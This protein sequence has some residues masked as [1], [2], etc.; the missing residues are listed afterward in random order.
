MAELFEAACAA[1]PGALALVHGET[2][3][4]YAELN[5]RANRLAWRL[6][7]RGVGPGDLVGL[8]VPRSVEMIVAWLGVLKSGAAYLPIDPS[9]PA[10]R[11]ALILDDARPAVIVSTLEVAPTLGGAEVVLVDQAGADLTASDPADA[12]R[13]RP[14]SLDDAAYVIFTSGSTGRP[15]GCVVTHRGVGGMAAE[16]I[17]RLRIGPG[18]RFLL[19]V[20]ISFDVS[21]ADIAMTLFAGATLVVP[22]PDEQMAGE[23]LADVIERHGVTHTDLVAAM[24]ASLPDRPL[25]TMTS[26]IVGGEACSR[27]LAARWAPGRRLVHVYGPTESTVVATMSEP[28]TGD[29]APPM[30]RPIRGIAA[31]VLDA[32]L[33]PVPDG[34]PGELYLAGA[35][36]ARG[37]LNR[38]ALTAERFV[39]NPFDA[40][41]ARMYRTGDLVKRLPSGEL[42]F[43]G[44]ADN[45]VKVRGFRI[46]LG[47]IEATISG[48]PDVRS[49]A[50]VVNEDAPGQKRLVA[51][52][53][54][55]RPVG[56]AEV[57]AYAAATLP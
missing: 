23:V 10:D 48:H 46:E 38:P 6:I 7:A 16:H 41:G 24:L 47:E 11:I 19:A 17:D 26:V 57:R 3:L 33:R 32:D 9:Y 49:A 31:H 35:G 53:V 42:V 18:S 52:V 37:Y 14:V 12:D 28:A 50:V 21:M 51:Y 15:K 22:G 39:A 30:G 20:S 40:A 4:T 36:L 29:A 45:Q 43:V 8:A 55:D 13:T 1:D 44:R 5:A 34:E 56:P 54:A 25:P 27:E 2:E